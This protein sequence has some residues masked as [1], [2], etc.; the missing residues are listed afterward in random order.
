[1]NANKQPVYL[2]QKGRDDLRR[3]YDELIGKKRPQ[4]VARVAR[5][6][7]FGDLTENSEYAAAREEL[8]LIDNR[9]DKLAEILKQAKVLRKKKKQQSKEAAL[10]ST[11]VLKTDVGINEFIIVG[12]LEADPSKGKLSN[13]SMVGKALLGAKVNDI[14]TVSSQI[15]TTY[16]IIGIR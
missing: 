3:E 13:E 10:G 7:D 1:M 16:K 14:V 11:V 8:D 12:S 15:K 5:A 2:T 9:I 4:L 6:R